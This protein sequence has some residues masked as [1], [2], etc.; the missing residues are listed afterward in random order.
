[1]RAE[2]LSRIQQSIIP[3]GSTVNAEMGPAAQQVRT[4]AT[5]D[6]ATSICGITVFDIPIY[7]NSACLFQNPQ[8]PSAREGSSPSRA[9]SVCPGRLALMQDVCYHCA[10]P[11]QHDKLRTRWRRGKLR[12]YV[13][14]FGECPRVLS[15]VGEHVA[16]YRTPITVQPY[17]TCCPIK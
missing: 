7:P 10:T 3:R 9:I 2:T 4:E 15:T 6:I 16:R 11:K 8:T 1:M 14:R 17:R 12:S 5:F 13:S